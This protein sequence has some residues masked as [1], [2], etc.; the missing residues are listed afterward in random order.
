VTRRIWLGQWPSQLASAWSSRRRAR[1]HRL[2]ETRR[3]LERA[4]PER[5]TRQQQDR[6][7]AAADRANRL[8]LAEPGR[9]TWM[10]DRIYAVESIARHRYG[11][12]LTFGWPR[13][14]L[15]LPDTTRAELNGAHS[16]FAAAVA[17]GTWALPYLVLGVL[18]WP[19]VLIAAA[20]GLTGWARA[21][22][23][24]TDLTAL[25]EAAV[26]LHG[27]A[28]AAALGV[29]NPEQDGPLTIDE[30]EKATDRMRKGR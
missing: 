23:A 26:D 24:V 27:R 7:D 13:L 10:G 29:A 25:A 18:W 11:L 2:V 9:P 4:D 8:A 15:V 22:A 1:W 19:A 17:T 21:R 20:V 28:L 16:V 14:W 30:G 5:R 12:D 3:S 6:I